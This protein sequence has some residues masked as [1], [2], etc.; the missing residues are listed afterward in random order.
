VWIP[1]LQN[2]V[3]L[4]L[5]DSHLTKDPME[6]LK[7]MQHLLILDLRYEAYEGLHL[8][9]EAGG[10]LKLKELNVEYLNELQDIIIDKG[11]LPSLKKLSLF[12]LCSLKNIPIGI[13][14]LKKLEALHIL[15]MQVEFVEHNSTEDW[16]M[17]HVPLF[18]IETIDGNV[19]RNSRS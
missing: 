1:E 12:G 18:E 17:E 19:I 7:C 9:V 3:V 6:S 4:R 8:H 13:I 14:H 5:M 2:L 11:A 10:F 16:I 15:D